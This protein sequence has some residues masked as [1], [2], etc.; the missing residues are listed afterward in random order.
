M[1]KFITVLFLGLPLFLSKNILAADIS[2]IDI[3]IILQ[4]LSP[5]TYVKHP[6][7]NVLLN[8]LNNA[9]PCGGRHYAI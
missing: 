2:V 7:R 9:S 3:S 4:Q 6:K 5:P 8:S 1:R